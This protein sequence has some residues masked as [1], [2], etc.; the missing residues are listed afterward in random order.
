MKQLPGVSRCDTRA[1]SSIVPRRD[2]PLVAFQMLI[3]GGALGDPADRAGLAALTAGLL[4]KG[5]GAIKS[6]GIGRRAAK[7]VCLD[8]DHPEIEDFIQWKQRE[9]KKVA[10]L[11]A[12]GS[13]P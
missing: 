8:A 10:V 2:V 9:E 4:D 6:G 7:M 1:S 12:A 3:R 11:V 5:A 13:I